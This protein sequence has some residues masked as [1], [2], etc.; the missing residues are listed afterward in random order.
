MER[1]QV[2][3]LPKGSFLKWMESRNKLG[4]QNK[5][6]R[7]YGNLKFIDELTKQ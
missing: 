5:V 1:L 4:G 6:P 2:I 7:L 3:A